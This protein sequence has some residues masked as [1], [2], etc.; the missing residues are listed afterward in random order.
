M[1]SGLMLYPEPPSLV[2]SHPL[3]V[4]LHGN[5][6]SSGAACGTTARG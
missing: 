6:A 5:R 1:D 3:L 2:G 4:L